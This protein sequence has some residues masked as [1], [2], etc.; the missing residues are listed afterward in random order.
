ML[1]NQFSTVT[2]RHGFHRQV[3]LL[4]IFAVACLLIG[5]ILPS[6]DKA[7]ASARKIR[8]GQ[9]FGDVFDNKANAFAYNRMIFLSK[10][11]VYD[12]R[13]GFTKRYD[14]TNKTCHGYGG[15]NKDGFGQI[16]LSNEEWAELLGRAKETL[17]DAI[18]SKDDEPAWLPEQLAAV[19][20]FL[21][22]LSSPPP[23]QPSGP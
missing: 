9:N 7:R 4:P 1:K 2:N 5:I 22:D 14:I 11:A 16:H 10:G 23:P 17:E 21:N 15:E 19:E 6:I 12:L 18:K 3:Q 8:M 13:D 20:A